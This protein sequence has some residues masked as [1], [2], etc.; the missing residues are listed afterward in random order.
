MKD[1]GFASSTCLLDL[2]NMRR[3]RNH[4]IEVPTKKHTTGL[5]FE[6]RMEAT[7]FLAYKE[8]CIQLVFLKEDHNVIVRYHGN[9]CKE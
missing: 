3:R 5:V 7:R 2:A 4:W 9:V 1:A 8:G 6:K